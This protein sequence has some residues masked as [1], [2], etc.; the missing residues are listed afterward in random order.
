MKISSFFFQECKPPQ[1]ITFDKSSQCLGQKQ[2]DLLFFIEITLPKNPQF[3]QG[4]PYQNCWK[5][6]QKST[7]FIEVTLSKLLKNTKKSII[8]IGF[9]LSKLLKKHKKIHNFHR[10]YP[11]KNV[12]K[13]YYFTWSVS[14]I[15]I[16]QIFS[17]KKAT[18]TPQSAGGDS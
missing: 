1:Q 4:L 16:N 10:G 14:F 17:L 18:R 8:F 5:N 12:W 7:I 3:W 13:I 9:T 11:I 6:T 15:K 2:Q